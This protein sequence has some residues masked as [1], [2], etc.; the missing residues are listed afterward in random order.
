MDVSSVLVG[1][2]CTY[3]CCSGVVPAGVS[4]ATRPAHA[5]H[6]GPPASLHQRG[7]RREAP[8][9]PGAQPCR[10]LALPAEE[11]SVGAVAGEE[12]RGPELH[13]RTTTGSPPHPH[14]TLSKKA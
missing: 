3:E 6:R 5:Q 13:E 12:G 10:R 9:V 11:E 1:L 2:L 4:G 14:T 7:P 8:Q